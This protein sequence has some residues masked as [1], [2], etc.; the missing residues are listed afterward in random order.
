MWKKNILDKTD[1]E[2]KLYDLLKI[3]ELSDD[4]I[5]EKVNIKEDEENDLWR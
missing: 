5:N 4:N 1:T 2:A 3:L